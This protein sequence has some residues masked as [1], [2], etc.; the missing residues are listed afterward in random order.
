MNPQLKFFN[1]L[2]NS[3][4]I[5]TVLQTYDTPENKQFLVDFMKNLHINVNWY[6]LGNKKGQLGKILA[7]S[8]LK[9]FPMGNITSNDLRNYVVFKD[10][11]GNF[12][13]NKKF[14][15]LSRVA[16]FFNTDATGILP[17]S[18]SLLQL[19]NY[20]KDNNLIKY[21]DDGESFKF[22]KIYMG[23]KGGIFYITRYGNKV[24]I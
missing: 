24:Y 3:Q 12:I 9:N 15:I 7:A 4:D 18:A 2:S 22:G 19:I 5:D 10:E 23:P 13:I 8:V 11:D 6:F 16:H 17:E 1:L 21:F 14:A 20:L